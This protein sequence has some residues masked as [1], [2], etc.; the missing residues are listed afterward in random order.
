[1]N[2]QQNLLAD[3]V[4]RFFDETVTPD[5]LLNAAK[6]E[7]PPALWDG[8]AA[9]GMT[10]P[11]VPETLGG[12]GDD[13]EAERIILSAAGYAAVPAPLAETMLAGW[14]LAQAGRQVPTGRLS[15]AL[16]TSG[17]LV[18]GRLD[19]LVRRVP[20][21]AQSQAIVIVLDQ[22]IALVPTPAL[23]LTP[24]RNLAGEPRDD[25]AASAAAADW[26]SKAPADA[27]TVRARAATMR[28][29]Q[30]VGAIA[31]VLAETTAY[32]QQRVQFGRPIGRFQA[33]QHQLAV[34]AGHAAA[35]QMAVTVAYRTLQR[36]G[37]GPA[38]VFAAAL[39]KGRVG[40]AAAVASTVG[41]QVHGAMGFT[42]EHL[43]HHLTKR[44]Q[45]WRSEFGSEAFW[46]EHAGARVL[47]RGADA[48]WPT[49]TD[50]F[51]EA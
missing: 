48:L 5:V 21:A 31:R 33:V 7:L 24:G 23:A 43:L 3:T 10:Q 41:H 29:A 39:A 14:L 9:L 45:A 36:R 38:F 15:A 4:R 26:I 25:V 17:K 51:E 27:L 32:A 34:L 13:F 2:D 40:E 1:M 30:M 42:Q 11:A 28:A 12:G 47:A 16:A 6:G 50:T 19:V 20:W 46:Q 44:L 49:M 37:A 18:E 22:E 35:A 8:I